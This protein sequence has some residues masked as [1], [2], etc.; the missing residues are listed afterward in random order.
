MSPAP[1]VKATSDASDARAAAHQDLPVR[2][3]IHPGRPDPRIHD[4]SRPDCTRPVPEVHPDPWLKAAPDALDPYKSDAPAQDSPDASASPALAAEALLEPADAATISPPCRREAAPPAVPAAVPPDSA[5]PEDA[6]VA[7]A[8]K[9]RSAH[10]AV[11]FA[12]AEA[13]EC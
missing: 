1:P 12:A 7:M 5:W 10:P 13:M 11:S 2:D 4:C 3:Y 9:A 6:A 8:M